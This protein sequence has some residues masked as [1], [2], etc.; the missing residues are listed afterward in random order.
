MMLAPTLTPSDADDP[1]VPRALSGEILYGDDFTA[2]EIERWFEHERE[3]YFDLYYGAA[4][5]PAEAQ[6]QAPARAADPA[7]YGYS[8][9]VRQHCFDRLPRRDHARVLGLGSADGAELGPVLGRAESITILEPSDG[10]RASEIAGK[11]VR[12]VQ[13]D[14]SG[15][16]PF[17]DASFDLV[18]AFNVLHHIPNVSTVVREMQRVLAP[19]GH[20]LLMDS[21]HS[22]G[23]W[24]RPRRGLTRHERGIPL[25]IFRG[26]IDRAGLKVL[27]ETR[28]NLAVMSRLSPWLGRPVWSV[29]WA[30][31]LD[32]WLCRLPVWSRRYHAT[33]P[34]HK[35]RP[36]VAAYVLEKPAR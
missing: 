11:P 14:P 12:Y 30:V 16:M 10:F 36:V 24:R 33:R 28:C 22:M 9:L 34:W 27:R 21:T 4:R 13:P 29:P 3:G 1:R 6:A 7:A 8:E 31:R 26:L 18:V 19:G 2:Q 5:E 15:L 20:A 17:A 23:D 35:L 25:P 32:A